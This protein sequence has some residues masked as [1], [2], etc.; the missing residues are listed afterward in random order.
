MFF[1][2]FIFFRNFFEMASQVLS[3]L[4]KTLEKL[5]SDEKRSSL[6]RSSLCSIP[7][8]PRMSTAFG[9]EEDVDDLE[10]KEEDDD[11][12][13]LETKSVPLGNLK[14]S[15]DTRTSSGST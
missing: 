5:K 15:R 13:V 3:S 7:D 4:D 14:I 11:F 8:L 9:V 10:E 1:E 12:P 2:I 6:T